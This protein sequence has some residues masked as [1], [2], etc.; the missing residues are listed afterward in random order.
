[1]RKS[2]DKT[3]EQLITEPEKL[4][5]WISKLEATETERMET[6]MPSLNLEEYQR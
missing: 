2:Q 3:K 5:K 4:R 1:M 6:G